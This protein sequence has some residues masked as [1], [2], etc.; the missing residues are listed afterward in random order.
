MAERAMYF[1][2]NPLWSGGH[3]A[4]GATMPSA[5]W[6]LAEGATGTFFTT[7]VL[8]RTPTISLP[9]SRSRISRSMACR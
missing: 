5:S 4:A 6:F 1:G 8:L 9:I 3:A 7:F 2:T